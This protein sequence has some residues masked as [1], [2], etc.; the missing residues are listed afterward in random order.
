[1]SPILHPPRDSVRSAARSLRTD[2]AQ[3]AFMVGEAGLEPATR[4]SQRYEGKECEL[5]GANRTAGPD[6]LS[7]RVT[8]WQS[9]KL[10]AAQIRKGSR[11]H[12]EAKAVRGA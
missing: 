12:E 1:M 4:S 3:A 8:L 6:F 11:S 10:A 9:K 5:V 2:N 7:S